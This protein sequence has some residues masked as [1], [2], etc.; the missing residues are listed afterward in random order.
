[1]TLKGWKLE[2]HERECNQCKIC[3]SK[4]RLTVHHK[5]PVSRGGAGCLSNCVCWCSEC[6]RAYHK[7]WGLTTSD[8]YGNPVGPYH[9]HGSKKKSR[10]SR[11]HAKKHTGKRRR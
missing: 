2:V 10:K 7:K 9:S 1:V 8:D 6:H 4:Y 5:L 3:G 11:K